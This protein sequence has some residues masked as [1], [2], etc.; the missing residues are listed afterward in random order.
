MLTHQKLAFEQAA[1]QL[2]KIG[3]D[4]LDR[5]YRYSE[6]LIQSLTQWGDQLTFLNFKPI[7]KGRRWVEIYQLFG[8]LYYYQGSL[9]PIHEE[10]RTCP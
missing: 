5:P 3:F 10:V 4:V 2:C 1:G 6:Q 9:Q 7:E 8:Y